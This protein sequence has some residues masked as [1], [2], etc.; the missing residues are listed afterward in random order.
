MTDKKI[1]ES[2]RK[3]LKSLAAG[4][5]AVIAGKSLPD[6]WK[7]PIVD[8]VMLPAHAQ[9]SVRTYFLFE[10]LAMVSDQIEEKTI[11]A[12]SMDKLLAPANAGSPEFDGL[13]YACVTI[14]G[15]VASVVWM[16]PFFNT[17]RRGDIMLGDDMRGEGTITARY[18]EDVS[19]SESCDVLEGNTASLTRPARIDARDPGFVILEIRT[20]TGEWASPPPIPLAGRCGLEPLLDGV[21]GGGGGGGPGSGGGSG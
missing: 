13:F 3:L 2:R 1:I 10:E 7:Q 15:N 4:S 14:N 9:T 16:S 19:D 6:E 5:G 18:P 11:L 17:I 8:S 20:K 12:L 21:C